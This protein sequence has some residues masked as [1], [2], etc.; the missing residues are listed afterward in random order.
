[1]RNVPKL[2]REGADAMAK[3]G[4]GD[5]TKT[6][7]TLYTNRYLDLALRLEPAAAKRA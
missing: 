3:A 6:V 7:D 2:W 4:L 1:M 5:L